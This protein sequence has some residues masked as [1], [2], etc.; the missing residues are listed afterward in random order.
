MFRLAQ[1]CRL[2]FNVMFSTSKLLAPEARN[3]FFEIKIVENLVESI[4]VTRK[5]SAQLY[6]IRRSINCS[7][8]IPLE[9]EYEVRAH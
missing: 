8:S 5:F 7:E 9:I 4:S 6:D 2:V 3:G 1:I